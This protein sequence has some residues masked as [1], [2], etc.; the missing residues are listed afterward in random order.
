MIRASTLYEVLI[1]M[2]LFISVATISFY[3][4]LNVQNS[5][6]VKYD[7][8]KYENVINN[9]KKYPEHGIDKS[10]FIDERVELYNRST[11]FILKSYVVISD[12]GEELYVK[13]ELILL[14]HE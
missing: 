10:I 7:V 14:E 6:D 2:L 4:L 12:K 11:E 8:L 3:M 1:A 9:Y 5:Y 13:K